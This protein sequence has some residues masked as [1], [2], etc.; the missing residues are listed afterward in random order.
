MKRYTTWQA[1]LFCTVALALVGGFSMPVAATAAESPK[2][3]WQ[4]YH[5][6]ASA[7][8]PNVVYFK[9]FLDALHKESNGAITA[10]FFFGGQLPIKG[11]QIT[12][13]LAQN[14]IQIACDSMF[15]GVVREAGILQSPQ[16][17][18][19]LEEGRTVWK[20]L[21]EYL[22]PKFE[23]KGVK[24]LSSYWFDPQIIYSKK[25][26]KSLADL[27]GMK[28]RAQ[29]PEQA[30]F[31][32]LL[33]IQ[34]VII[35]SDEVAQASERGIIDGE[36]TGATGGGLYRHQYFKYIYLLP[37]SPVCS[38]FAM[39]LKT[40]NE[41]PDNL[42]QLT[43]SLAVKYAEES[44]DFMQAKSDEYLKKFEKEG[45]ILVPYTK[46]DEKKALE[47]A[48]TYWKSW[49]TNLGPEVVDIMNRTAAAVK[50]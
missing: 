37:I 39:N 14:N 11:N 45:L 15:S 21:K 24:V 10:N 17:V 30:S 16:L 44:S 25:S 18:V 19:T 27:K 43:Q 9:K 13:A 48:K 29:G 34:G 22:I 4:A 40:Y 38:F 31:Y 33:G 20:A 6:T 32:R 8:N 2:Y 7:D 5:F 36:T 46:E 41:L 42:K 1:L 12:T 49:A 3:Q 35:P 23:Q 26:M 47:A 28:I 50:K